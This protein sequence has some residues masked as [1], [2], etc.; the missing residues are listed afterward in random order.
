MS[1]RTGY[2][3]YIGSRPYFGERAAQ[4]VQNLVVRDYC[5]RNGHRF[6]L[7]ATEY[8]M[9]GCYMMLEEVFRELPRIEGVVLY[10]IFMLPRS[11]VRRRRVYDTV[12][13]SGATLAGAL[14]NLA[15]RNE[16]DIRAVEDIWSI[17]LLTETRNDDI[18][19]FL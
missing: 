3:G 15:V 13:G 2:R 5:Q 8:A 7:S 17:K 12:L 18:G 10:S 6:L 9:N 4:H 16:A 14:E 11:R 1:E 19:A